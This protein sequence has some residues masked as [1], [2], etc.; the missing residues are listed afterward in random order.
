MGTTRTSPHFFNSNQGSRP[1]V[2]KESL[3]PRSTECDGRG[4]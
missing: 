3:W 1:N 2:K 4:F